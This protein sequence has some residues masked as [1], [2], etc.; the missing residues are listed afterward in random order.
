MREEPN[1]KVS[2]F[3]SF[4]YD[5]RGNV[6]VTPYLMGWNGKRFKVDKI[7]LYHPERRGTKRIHIF[8]FLAD[9]TTFKVELD[10][11]SLE[12]LLVGVHYG[13]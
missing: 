3:A 9:E 6:L 7:G 2:V 11:D 5:K 13:A 8:S 12:W 1:E 10:P 4:T